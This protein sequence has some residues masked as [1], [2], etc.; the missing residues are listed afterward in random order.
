MNTDARDFSANNV[1]LKEILS[2][3][4]KHWKWFVLSVIIALMFAFVYIRYATPE[5]AA[6][7]KIQIL[8][9]KTSSTELS[10]FQDLS[11]IGGGKNKVE[12]E[13][14]I[15][16]SRSNFI[17]VVKDLGLNVQV[18]ALGNVK[19]SEIYT[20]RPI[21]INFIS[22]DS[23]IDRSSAEFYLEL[24]S[25]TTFG[26]SMEADAPVKIYSFGK[27]VTTDIGDIIITPNLPFFNRYK[28]QRIKVVVKPLFVIAEMYQRKIVVTPAQE[29]SNIMDITLNDAVKKKAVDIIDALIRTYNKNA[30]EDKRAVA[31]K[32]SE[33]I[34]DRIELISGTLTAVD[35]DAQELLTEKGMTGG[36]L[37]VGA[38]VQVS[39][40]SRQQLEN[41]RVQLQMVRGMKEYVN[42]ESGY[43]EM[44]VVDVGSGTI[45]E[46]TAKYNQLVAERKR[47]LKSADEKN[48]MIVNLDQQLDGLRSTMQS[49]LTAM[50]RNV[51]MNVGTLQNQMGRIQG[52]IYS[53]PKNQ[54]ELRNITRQQET[55]EALYLYLLQKREESQ[56]SAASSPA[57][58]KIVD[59]AYLV[60]SAPVTPKKP[61]I[62]LASL[63]LGL[64]VPFSLIY[65]NDLLDNKIHNKV[66]LEKML[67]DI[68][69]LA[70]LPRLGKKDQTLVRKED[71]SVLGES[72]RILRTNLDYLIKSKH[73]GK[74]N[75]IYV[76]SSVPGEGKTFLSSNLA[77]IFA[78][79]DKKVILIGAD[80]RNPKLYTFFSSKDVDKLGKTGRNKDSGLT[81]FLYDDSLTSK[82][83]INPMLAYTNTI[84]VIYSGK[85]PPN[86]SELLMSDR[87]KDLLTEMSLKYD[88]V[89]VDTAP[90]M[91]VTDTLLISDYADHIIYVT[92]AGMTETKVI[93]FPMKLKREG[94][95]KG[96][97]FVVN[98]VKESNLGYGGK[99]GYGYGKSTKKWWRF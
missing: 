2:T 35:E 83:I 95:L 59:N 97:S 52:T 53:A 20:N 75:V 61:L 5:Y 26:L 13:I 99:Y 43:E 98:D 16:N 62:L 76:T 68:P 64:L 65:G 88:Y 28:G 79:T 40:A 90:L 11:L 6:K 34:N 30:I 39:A 49:S 47:L 12:D 66:G 37:E 92:R 21:K 84:D 67:T 69:V 54:R 82:D 70:E 91:V 73:G 94:K 41:A 87:M 23:I 71:R 14:E 8:E 38:A 24:S 17:Q 89:I 33:F 96:L 51:G 86:P 74:N 1:D 10:A 25:D 19:D 18:I 22:N 29:F 9:D 63:I 81:E 31:D 36:G 44:P 72:L 80:I 78:N 48:P 85:I 15:L 7:A 46:T 56:I 60:G 58:S 42:Q 50:E 27:S 57:K 4:T 3:Y 93:D 32:T 77:M 55:T 45:T